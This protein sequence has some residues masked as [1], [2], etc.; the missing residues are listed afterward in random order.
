MQDNFLKIRNLRTYFFTR[1][2]VVKAVDGVDIEAKRGKLTALVGESG[3]G[4]SVTGLSIMGLIPSP[5]GKI[6]EGEILFEDKDLAK[7]SYKEMADLRGKDISMIFQEPMTSLNPV[8]TIGHQVGEPLRIHSSLSPEEITE[9]VLSILDLVG[10]PEPRSRLKSYPHQLSGGMR[11]RVMIAMAMICGPKLLIADEPTTA[12]DVTIQAQI[13]D[14]MLELMKKINTSIILITHDLGVVAEVCDEV[15]VMYA[16][17][18]VEK[19]DVFSIFDN[20]SH[21]YTW[22]LLRS[23]PR[24]GKK[25]KAKKLYTIKGVVPNLLD[26][27][28]GCRFADRCDK[29]R[30]ICREEEPPFTT[31]EEGH[32][33]KCWLFA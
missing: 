7:L 32:F 5:V 27:P 12:L 16:G 11:Q 3:C 15:N 4:K 10:I 30:D 33:V 28:S 21:P 26:P 20:P 19:S 1:R 22:G 31:I 14:L 29:A 24:I 25:G 6:V 8:L 13:L 9:R 23:I 17:K 2:G 18:I